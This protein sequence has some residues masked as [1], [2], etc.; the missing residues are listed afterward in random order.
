MPAISWATSGTPVT[1][2]GPTSTS[3]CTQVADRR[4]TRT[5]SSRRRTTWRRRPDVDVTARLDAPCPPEALFAVVEDLGR[6]PQWLDIVPR[7]V[8]GEGRG[9]EPAWTVDLR[10]RLGPFARS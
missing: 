1:P 10:G 6:Y 5:R 8:A 4:S 9:D 3:R 2:T 7:A